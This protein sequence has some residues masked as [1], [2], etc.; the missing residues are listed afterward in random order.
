VV[1]DNNILP[2]DSRTGPIVVAAP[3]VVH[4][5]YSLRMS[6]QALSPAAPKSW[7]A[8]A[9]QLGARDCALSLVNARLLPSE[10]ILSLGAFEGLGLSLGLRMLTLTLGFA[11]EKMGVPVAVSTIA[12]FGP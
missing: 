8:P 2:S 11:K 6:A 1:E 7:V 5:D 3:P 10:E 4:T 9:L 12:P